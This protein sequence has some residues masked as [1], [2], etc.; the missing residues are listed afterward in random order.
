MSSATPNMETN[1]TV[2]FQSN[3][4]DHHHPHTERCGSPAAHATVNEVIVHRRPGLVDGTKILCF[5][6]CLPGPPLMTVR[7]N[8][9]NNIALLRMLHY[10]CYTIASKTLTLPNSS[11]HSLLRRVRHRAAFLV[12]GCTVD[13]PSF[14]SD[15]ITGLSSYKQDLPDVTCIKMKGSSNIHEY[16]GRKKGHVRDRISS[17]VSWLMA[18]EIFVGKA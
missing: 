17:H 3:C 5:P 16:I 6:S 14:Q 18:P 1:K 4:F 8:P 10:G 13:I 12:T 2:K 9:E 15:F 7:L 11:L